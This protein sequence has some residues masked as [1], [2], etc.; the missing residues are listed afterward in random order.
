MAVDLYAH[1]L[2][3]FAAY[4]FLQMSL[5]SNTSSAW[6][7]AQVKICMAEMNFYYDVCIKSKGIDLRQSYPTQTELIIFVT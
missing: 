7:I 6:A 3:D 5:Q 1:H 2:R 4:A